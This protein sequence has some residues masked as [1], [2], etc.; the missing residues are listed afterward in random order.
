MTEVQEH[1]ASPVAGVRQSD[2]SS[3]E[4]R[5]ASMISVIEMGRLT[6]NDFVLLHGIPSRSSRGLAAA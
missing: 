2:V 1:D 4:Q 5:R 6:W 3:A